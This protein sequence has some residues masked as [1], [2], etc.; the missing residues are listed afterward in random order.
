[1]TPSCSS[2]RRSILLS[3]G[4]SVVLPRVA[5]SQ[6][7]LQ[8]LERYCL[9]HSVPSAVVGHINA[10]GS[11]QFERV[12][13][14]PP[15]PWT[16]APMTRE[17]AY[18]IGSVGKLAL[19]F[20]ALDTLRQ[21]AIDLDAA[22]TNYLPK[23][24]WQQAI[25]REVSFRH[26]GQHLSGLAEPIANQSFQAEIV[27]QPGRKWS[28]L[29][30][31]N[32]S[33]QQNRRN[34]PGERFNYSN[35]NSVLLAKTLE[36][37]RQ[38]PLHDLVAELRNSL[39]SSDCLISHPASDDWRQS[40]LRAFRHARANRPMG[41]GTLFSDVT[42]Y[43]P[44]W[45]GAGGDWSARIADLLVLG[46]FLMQKAAQNEAFLAPIFAPSAASRQG[47]RGYGFHCMQRGEWYGHTGDV[48]G[49]S[50]ALWMHRPTGICK[51]AICN[52]SNTKTGS[53]PADELLW[54]S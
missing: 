19:G 12:T 22:V 48:P 11:M 31:L 17:L 37:I 35:A 42:A 52:L 1:M 2:G 14:S 45:S 34:T 39:G 24:D 16:S 47:S 3:A 49:F 10:N 25:S 51:A 46:R 15:E 9:E 44:S 5:V 21:A 29:E 38:R 18:P 8:Q 50:A 7:R 54:L 36:V 23:D 28:A 32:A 33:V 30:A 53:N 40:G 6:T 43:N 4:L 27:A 13:A 41:Y 20:L 26:L